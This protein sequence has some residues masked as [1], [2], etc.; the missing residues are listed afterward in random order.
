MH[1]SIELISIVLLLLNFLVSLQGFSNPEI[2]DKYSF[3]V[4]RILFNREYYR[5]ITGSFLH[6]SWAHLIF[7]ML[8]LYL[9]AGP[10][11]SIGLPVWAFLLIYFGSAIGGDV[12]ALYLHRNHS[13]YSAV[14]ASGAVNGIIFATITLA[15][16]ISV[17][18][19]PGWLFGILYLA[20]TI[21]GIKAQH[22]STSHE[23]HLG[24]ALFGIIT[25]I[26][27]RPDLIG[28]HP[29]VLL[30]LLLPASIFLYLIV[31]RPEMLMVPNSLRQEMQRVRETVGRPTSQKQQSEGFK[32][33]EEE[34]NHLLDKGLENLTGKERKRLEE[35]SR[36]LDS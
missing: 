1:I 8:A 21:Y 11:D 4:D 24:G 22:G 7:N 33:P 20:A 12:L 29:L 25:A 26:G 13:D 23:A 34:I 14:G 2:V 19:M 30:G 36:R 27:Y 31:T 15:P 32:S 28:Q 5:F 18:F 35:L 17:W 16:T 10:L 3:R 9:F 6:T